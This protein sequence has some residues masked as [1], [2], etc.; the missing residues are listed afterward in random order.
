[1]SAISKS[2]NKKG[3]D[4][5]GIQLFSLPK[6]LD[7]DFLGSIKMLAEMGYTQLE[8]FGPYPFSH[9][10]AKESWKGV[11]AMLG[12]S[13]SGYFGNDIKVFKS[14]LDDHGMTTPSVHSDWDT[15]V[16]HM[17]QLGEAA[18]TLGYEYVVL[19][20]IPDDKRKTS[21]DYKR[22]AA[23]FN[24][25]G[26]QARKNGI[27]FAY[28]NHGYGLQEEHGK[29]PLDIIFAETDPDLVFFE[30]DIYWTTAGGV[31]PISLLKKYGQRYQLLH[32]K[33]MQPKKQFSGDGNDMSQWMEMFPYMT[34]AGE[35]ELGVGEIV[36]TALDIGAQ[37][38]FVEQDLVA[39][40]EVALAKSI[41][42]LKL[43]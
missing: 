4:N 33:D 3:L 35:G 18:A 25:I 29:M 10:K 6:S 12:F 5:I 13:G 17:D 37:Y 19:P 28:H 36:K 1:M 38:F 42:Y 7:K 39:N 30:M 31:N 34:S 41:D 22:V 24:E 27:R 32:L 21:D 20:A 43:V 23:T 8:L 9:T 14:I 40:P 2:F 11:G 15:L 16:E 26:E